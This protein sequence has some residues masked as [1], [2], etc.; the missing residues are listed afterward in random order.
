ML[1][2]SGYIR[3]TEAALSEGFNLTH[4]EDIVF[5]EPESGIETSLTLL[6][7]LV[8]Q[9]STPKHK[10]TMSI[11]TKWDGAPAVV[12]GYDPDGKYFVSLKGVF[13][14]SNPKIAYSEREVDAL[15]QGEVAS[16][17]KDC[18][19][20]LKSVIPSSGIYLGDLLFTRG[21]KKSDTINGVSHISFRPNT[22]TY[23][24]PAD[25]PIGMKIRAAE[26]GIVFHTEYSG[27]DFKSM[28]SSPLSSFSR[29][30]KSTN[31][32]VTD[33][34]L[35]KPPSGTF[36]PPSEAAT[37]AAIVKQINSLKSKAKTMAVMLSKQKWW[38]ELKPTINGAVRAGISSV[39]TSMLK[40]HLTT[41]YTVASQKLKTASGQEKKMQEL[42]E[43]LD[44]IDSYSSQ[45][46]D[47]FKVHGLLAQAK[48]I[49]INQL[50][51]GSNGIGTYVPTDNGLKATAPEGFVA[52]CGKT[53]QVIKLVDRMEFS[54]MNFNLAKDWKK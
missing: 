39:N 36:V 46:D 16:K 8:T 49:I 30:K 52:V 43:A 26:M 42:K 44:F 4:L 19:R 28:R 51:I 45:I 23:A 47:L 54:R 34:T 6:N 15:Y 3:R 12:V 50:A 20:L 14:S 5:N 11:T 18:F 13:G 24:V 1:T 10:V 35:P 32:W 40:S 2:L 27:N 37:I 38:S 48:M 53:C 31:V 29:F 41:K 22:I 21:S 33:A 9:L 25:S 17:L 7:D